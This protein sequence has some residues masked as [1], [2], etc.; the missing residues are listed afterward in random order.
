VLL[1]L[2]LLVPIAAS[3]ALY[4]HLVRLPSPAPVWRRAGVVALVVAGARVAGIALG[5]YGLQATSG[6]LQLPAYF[7]VLLSWP[8]VHLLPGSLRRG[9]MEALLPLGLLVAAGSAAWSLAIACLAHVRR[10]RWRR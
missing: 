2:V 7:L 5:W 6:W 4:A 1:P 3:L 10:T 9:G 8:E